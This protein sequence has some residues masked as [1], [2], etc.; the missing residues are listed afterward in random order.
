M[1]VIEVKGL[2]FSYVRFF[3]PL[4]KNISFS[5]EQGT[6]LS[7]IGPNGSG[8]TTLF[9]L[10]TGIIRPKRNTVFVWGR[11]INSYQRKELVKYISALPSSEIIHNEVLRVDD[12]LELARYP[13]ISGFGGL[14]DV[15]YSIIET[16]KKITHTHRLGKKYLWELSQGELARVRIARMIAQDSKI[17]IMDEPTAH[18]DID[19]KLWFFGALRRMKANGKTVIAIIHDINFAYKFSDE[20]LVLNDGRIEFHGRKENVDFKLLERVFNVKIKRV[21]DDLI[22]EETF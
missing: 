7:I 17:L 1:K 3:E 6:F 14:R 21:N 10:L 8:K 16:A 11:D 15:D 19:H 5:V 2:S 12:Y 22:F 18:L 20:L 4:I 13:Y 9:R